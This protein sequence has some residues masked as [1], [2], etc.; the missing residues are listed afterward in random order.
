[1]NLQAPDWETS[2]DLEAA[3]EELP[4]NRNAALDIEACLSSSLQHFG[5]EGGGGHTSVGILGSKILGF[6]S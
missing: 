3:L 5:A 1:V 6:L 4:I 2:V